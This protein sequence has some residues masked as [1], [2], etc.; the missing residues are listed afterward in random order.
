[1]SAKNG[2]LKEVEQGPT[3][4]NLNERIGGETMEV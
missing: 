1:M 3:G 2:Y 4:G